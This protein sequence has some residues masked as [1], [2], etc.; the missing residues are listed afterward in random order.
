[1]NNKAVSEVMKIILIVTITVAIAAMVYIV[2]QNEVNERKLLV[3][4]FSEPNQA[5]LSIAEEMNQN[6]T[7]CYENTM[8]HIDVAE[9]FLNHNLTITGLEL[10]LAK[11]NVTIFHYF[12]CELVEFSMYPYIYITEKEISGNSTVDYTGTKVNTTLSSYDIVMRLRINSTFYN[13]SVKMALDIVDK[14]IE[15]AE[16]L[17]QEMLARYDSSARLYKE[18]IKY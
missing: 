11:K 8:L 3:P 1:M 13:T 6:I 14:Y 15:D 16:E 7:H 5:I 2:I 12:L 9:Y 10:D 4:E 17:Y 18:I